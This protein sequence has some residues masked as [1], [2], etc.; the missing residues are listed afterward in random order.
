MQQT[1]RLGLQNTVRLIGPVPDARE[2]IGAADIYLLSSDY[3]G[4]ANVVL[5]AMAAGV[6]SVSTRVNAVGDLIKPG[7]TGFIAEH[8]AGDLAHHVLLLAKSRALRQEIGAQVRSLVEQ[9]YRPEQIFPRLWS[10][11]GQPGAGSGDEVLMRLAI[12]VDQVF[13]RDGDLISTD[14]SDVLFL[15]SLAEFAEEIVLIGREA[16]EAGRAPYVLEQGV[17]SLLPLPVL[18]EPVRAVESGSTHLHAG[19]RRGPA[20]RGRTMDALLVCGPHPIGQM[21]ARECI[22]LGI[23]VGLVV[24]QHL[25]EQMSAH[26]GLKRLLAVAAARLLEWDFRRLGRGRTVFTVGAEMAAA[27]RPGQRARP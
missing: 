22:R 10:L 11:C 7:I 13:W 17:V 8:D 25:I 20:T 26:S 4:M 27:V 23:P 15:A 24:R 19:P 16:P 2:L 12:F 18:P 14:E 9:A 6:P 5:E 1:A 3:E 21:V